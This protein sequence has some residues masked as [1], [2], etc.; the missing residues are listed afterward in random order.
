MAFEYKL[1]F[2]YDETT[3]SDSSVYIQ[4]RRNTPIYQ[5][6]ITKEDYDV[7]PD[8]QKNAF[9]TGLFNISGVV[10]LSTKAYRIWVMKSPVFNW[11]EVLTPLLYYVANFYGESAITSLPGSAMID[12]SGFK[13]DAVIQ[14]R[15]I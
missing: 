9:L 7:L 1:E 8:I 3:P 6:H 10:E 15:K 4:M 14:R 5:S 12:G 11:E 13:I 2:T